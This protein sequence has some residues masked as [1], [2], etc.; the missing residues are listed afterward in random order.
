MK[1]F[2]PYPY[3]IYLAYRFYLEVLRESE[4]DRLPGVL[5][6]DGGR[7]VPVGVVLRLDNSYL[8]F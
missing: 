8:I 4:F 6:E 2:T 5:P 3:R 7:G 1:I